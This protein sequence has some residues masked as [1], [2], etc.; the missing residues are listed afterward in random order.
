MALQPAFVAYLN[1]FS[2]S[3]CNHKGHRESA[4]VMVN[5]R[6]DRKKCAY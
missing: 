6:K 5:R 2:T 4:Y 3:R 1:S